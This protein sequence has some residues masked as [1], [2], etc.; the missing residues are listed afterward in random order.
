MRSRTPGSGR[1]ARGACW[2]ARPAGQADSHDRALIQ[3]DGWATHCAKSVEEARPADAP[4]LSVDAA[5][6]LVDEALRAAGQH[7]VV[8]PRSGRGR[9]FPT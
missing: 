7:T 1:G 5:M 6:L 8:Q 4:R 9:V 3:R 2:S